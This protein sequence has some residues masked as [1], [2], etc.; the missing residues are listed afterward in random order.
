MIDA[1][2]EIAVQRMVLAVDETVAEKAIITQL[3]GIARS[4]LELSHF[5]LLEIVQFSQ[6][7]A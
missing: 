5:Q 3:R 7:N 2:K 1:G 6:S 4:Y